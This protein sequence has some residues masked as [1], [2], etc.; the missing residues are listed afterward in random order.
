M[1]GITPVTQVRGATPAR[2]PAPPAPPAR[3]PAHGGTSSPPPAKGTPKL[4]VVAG[5]RPK[6]T[7]TELTPLVHRI[8]VHRTTKPL[9]FRCIV[10]ASIL[11]CIVFAL[12]MLL[13]PVGEQVVIQVMPPPT[14]VTVIPEPEILPPAELAEELVAL[15]QVDLTAD[16]APPAVEPEPQPGERYR[17]A[18]PLPP[19]AG[20]VGR[21]RAKEA[22]S[23]LAAATASLDKTLSGI[24][25]SLRTPDGSGR[26]LPRGRRPRT[27]GAGRSGGE[28][29]PVETGPV[30]TGAT[31]DLGTSSVEGAKL[32]IG[33][34]S[35]GGATGG[36]A[37]ADG[38]TT[39]SGA[40]PGVYRTNASL[41]AVIQKYAAGIQWCYENELKKDPT[42]R[43]KMVVAITVS[44]AGRVTGAAVIE[45]T[46]DSNRLS[47]C[48]LS[49]VRD[50]RFPPVPEGT[51]A[52]QAPFVFTPP[53]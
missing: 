28:V 24:S 12:V 13:E 6:Q 8:A 15:D 42:L 41:L 44:A 21:A 18:P 38:S 9:W 36:A 27:T 25:S 39:S 31:A 51:T 53:K 46:V 33:Q 22:T 2:P 19:D 23:K 20:K 45:N 49:Q 26:P 43:G 1:H 14:M 11:A 52:F 3:P 32:R 5:K 34:L 37:G 29:G 48:A 16:V 35:A 47:S 50:W 30:G 40:A 4:T 10:L 7:I 17:P